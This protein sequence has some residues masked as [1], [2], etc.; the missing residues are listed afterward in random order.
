MLKSSLLGAIVIVAVGFGAWYFLAAPDQEPAM[1]GSISGTLSYPSEGV[2]SMRVCAEPLSGGPEQCVRTQDAPPAEPRFVIR[3][4]APGQ[5]HVYAQLAD[6]ES[7]GLE[8]YDIAR[9]K[10]YYTA[11]VLCGQHASCTDH[12]L[13]TVPVSAGEDTGDVEPVDWYRR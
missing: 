7:L 2:P 5:Y 8:A 10:A 9:V 6:P 12:A 4:L 3:D 1:V 13:V 11:F